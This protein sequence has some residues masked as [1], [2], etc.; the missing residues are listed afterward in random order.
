MVEQKKEQGG[1][2]TLSHLRIHP[3]NLTTLYP[4]ELPL[5]L[6]VELLW[7]ASP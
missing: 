6:P 2:V 1:L 5:L 3:G 4:L 7:G